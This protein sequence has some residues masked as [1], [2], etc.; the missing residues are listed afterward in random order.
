MKDTCGTG[1]EGG[2]VVRIGPEWRRSDEAEWCHAVALRA[3]AGGLREAVV[4]L[5]TRDGR[6]VARAEGRPVSLWPYVAGRWAHQQ[7][8]AQSEQAARLL[9]RLHRALAEARVPPRPVSADLTVGL[10]GDVRY[11]HPDLRDAE[12]D[13]WLA[14]FAKRADRVHAL[15][16]DYYHGNLLADGHGRLVAVLDWDEALIAPPEVELAGAALE[17]TGEFAADLAACRGFVDAYLDEGGTVEALDD[18]TMVQLMRHRLRREAAHYLRASARGEAFDDEDHV[19]HAGRM[20][21]FAALR[22]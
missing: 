17:F 11:D 19:Y 22:P 2:V 3:A 9:A 13:E 6:T 21:A 10:S 1:P 7:D 20:A 8:P 16:G 14:G 15:H 18:T 5:R 12:L 4:P